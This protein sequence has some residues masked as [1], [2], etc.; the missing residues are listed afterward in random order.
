MKVQLTTNT[1]R[2][3][4]ATS[5][6]TGKRVMNLHNLLY[7][8]HETY[9]MSE[10]VLVTVNGETVPV[11]FDNT[12]WSVTPEFDQTDKEAAAAAIQIQND[13]FAKLYA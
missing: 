1:R 7:R 10:A 9:G 12:G 6:I 4:K 13:R 2:N 11:T 5:P 3:L 8:L